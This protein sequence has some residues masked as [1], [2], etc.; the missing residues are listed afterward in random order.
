MLL[1][2]KDAEADIRSAFK[3]YE[4]QKKGLGRVFI[5]EIDRVI[6][7][8]EEQPELYAEVFGSVRRAL[9][10]RF[11]Y[12]VYFVRRDLHVIILGVLHQRRHPAVWQKRF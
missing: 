4:H 1:L 9:S 5:A 8:V 10:R 2:R 6:T 3:W 12:A 7:S 11:P